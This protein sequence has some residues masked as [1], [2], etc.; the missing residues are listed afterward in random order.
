MCGCNGVYLNA[1]YSAILD[2]TAAWSS[3]TAEKAESGSL[4]AEGMKKALLTN[5]QI[6]ASF[7]DARDGIFKSA[8][9]GDD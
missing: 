9:G 2:D 7:Q 1:K 8:E 3:A 6:W 4:D 5:A